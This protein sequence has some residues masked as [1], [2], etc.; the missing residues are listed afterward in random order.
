MSSNQEGSGGRASQGLVRLWRMP[1]GVGVILAVV[2]IPIIL[3]AGNAGPFVALAALC[4]YPL[5]DVPHTLRLSSWWLGAAISAVVWIMV[6]IALVVAVEA[7]TPLREA[8]LVFLLPFMVYPL[9]L[10]LSGLVR[11]EG[12]LSGRPRESGPRIARVVIGVVCGLMV[13]GPIV[14]N[15]IPAVIQNVTGDTPP[16]T[17]ISAD[18]DV[19]SAAPGLITVRFDHGKVESFQLR[20]DTEFSFLGSGW[21]MQTSPAG[22]DWLKPGQRVGL[23]YVYRGGKGQANQVIIWVERK[24]CAGDVKWLAA[25]QAAAPASAASPVLAGTVWEGRVDAPDGQPLQE[26]TTFE[27]LEGDRA[28]YRDTRS[29]GGDARWKQNGPVVLIEIND[30]YALY[31]GRIEGDAITGEFSNVVG[32]RA[33]WTARRKPR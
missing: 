11:L 21:R 33:P 30:C 4:L 14:M 23:R 1:G 27:F 16:N 18:G 7:V 9:A 32:A 22:P 5:L 13:L 8:S 20:P 15:M 31:D 28:K 10:A 25:S 12:W 19:V 6:F 3:L 17:T 24:G 29:G 26:T 2:C